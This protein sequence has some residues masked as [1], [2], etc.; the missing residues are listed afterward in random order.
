MKIGTHSIVLESKYPL[1]Q[2][3]Y[4]AAEMGFEGYEIDIGNYGNTGFGIQTPLSKM[5]E[6]ER[7]SIKKVAEKAGIEIC[8]LCLG[9]LWKFSLAS[10]DPQIR[11]EGIRI[12]EDAIELASFLNSKVILVPVGQPPS[13]SPREARMNLVKSIRCC[14]KKAKE[15]KVILGIENAGSRTI[16]TAKDIIEVVDAVASPWCKAYYDVGNSSFA[17][18]KPHQE[19]IELGERI[20]QVHLKDVAIQQDNIQIV[21]IGK[22]N[23]DY[24]TVLQAL[25]K[26]NYDG[27]L[28]L[29][30]PT[31]D[32]NADSIATHSK[33]ELI[34]M[35][36]LEE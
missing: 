21:S 16:Y 33:K 6:K 9:I 7:K 34:K 1:K 2:A 36:F 10:P 13:I 32:E 25:K 8:S 5:S 20:V 19:I 24:L 22:G 15:E 29:E 23:I 35:G 11:T 27:Y 30:I 3:L 31:N 4:K 26:V 12:I 17:G 28:V 18:V 14:L